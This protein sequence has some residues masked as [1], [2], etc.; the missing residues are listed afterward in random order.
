MIAIL[1]IPRSLMIAILTIP[2]SLMIAILTTPRSL[3]IAILTIPQSLVTHSNDTKFFDDDGQSSDTMSLMIACLTILGLWL[4]SAL[5]RK[6][7]RWS[8]LSPDVRGPS[9][10]WPDPHIL[11]TRSPDNTHTH[12]QTARPCVPSGLGRRSRAGGGAEGKTWGS[13]VLLHCRDSEAPHTRGEEDG[14]GGG[15][16]GIAEACGGNRH[17]HTL[18]LTHHVRGGKSCG[19]WQ[20]KQR[21][22]KRSDVPVKGERGRER[23]KIA[24]LARAGAGAYF[25]QQNCA[26]FITRRQSIFYGA[27]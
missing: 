26:P 4:K 22:E 17:T 24:E 18:S 27:P 19:R 2:R 15:G 3:V 9:D 13:S 21:R 12:T 16:R 5:L 10:T 6:P 7:A 11:L 8:N 23:K 25:S 14:E 1:T 20:G